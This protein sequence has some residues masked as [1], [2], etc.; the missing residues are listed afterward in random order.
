LMTKSKP[1]A[2]TTEITIQIT[3]DGIGNLNTKVL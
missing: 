2:P 1:A 3:I